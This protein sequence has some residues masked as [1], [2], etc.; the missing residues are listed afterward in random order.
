VPVSSSYTSPY[1]YNLLPPD[2]IIMV[3]CNPTGSKDAQTHTFGQTTRPFFAKLYITS[4]FLQISEQMVHSTFAGFQRINS[5]TVEFQNPDG[6]LVEFN[7]RP[8]SFSLLFTLYENSS[9]TTCF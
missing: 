3:L 8:H 2:Y 7:G 4:P 5:V 1:C 6:T 9:E